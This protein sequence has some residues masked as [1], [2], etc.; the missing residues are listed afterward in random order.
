[1]L[2]HFKNKSM[3]NNNKLCTLDKYII[4]QPY[5][6]AIKSQMIIAFIEPKIFNRN[7]KLINSNYNPLNYKG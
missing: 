2:V 3:L 1:M 7:K 5:K 4:V 6:N